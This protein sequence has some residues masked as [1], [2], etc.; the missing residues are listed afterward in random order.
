MTAEADF[1]NV[2]TAILRKLPTDETDAES[3]SGKAISEY[4]EAL[5][6]RAGTSTIPVLLLTNA[7]EGKVPA[8]DRLDSL[9]GFAQE[10]FEHYLEL[11]VQDP[12]LGPYEALGRHLS[13]S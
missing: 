11:K 3:R 12:R 10:Q 2:Q 5:L 13:G 4:I 7:I 1:K 9:T 6:Q 8:S